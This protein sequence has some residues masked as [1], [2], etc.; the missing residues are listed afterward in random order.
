MNDLLSAVRGSFVER[1]NS[2]NSLNDVEVGLKAGEGIELKE[3]TRFENELKPF[4]EDIEKIK[5]DLKVIKQLTA[6]IT[7]MHEA[8]KE[9]VRTKDVQQH[10]QEIQGKINHIINLAQKAKIKLEELDS[11]SE[12]SKQKEGQ[13][14]GSAVER[15]RCT[16]T[17]GLRKK[18]K[19]HM[20]DFTD[21]RNAIHEDNK[22]VRC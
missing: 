11:D 21:L 9:I 20:S 1:G 13:G 8:G 16:V 7:D 22:E 12:A 2:Y 6:E 10:K 3:G 4:F 15:T 5:V 14:E 17:V 19:E 18:L